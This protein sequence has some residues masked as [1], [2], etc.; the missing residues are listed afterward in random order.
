MQKQKV[1]VE[2]PKLRKEE[3]FEDAPLYKLMLIEDDD[4]DQGHVME[5]ICDICDDVDENEAADIYKG[6]MSA[7]KAMIGKYPMER[8]ELR[9]EQLLRSDPI[10]FGK[11]EDENDNKEKY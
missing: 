1:K 6:C 4:Y 5:R 2:E 7:G 3:K 10:I 9:L 11:I 8:A